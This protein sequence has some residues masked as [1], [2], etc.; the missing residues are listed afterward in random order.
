[1][2]PGG[3]GSA[4]AAGSGAGEGGGGSRGGGKHAESEG[5]DVWTDCKMLASHEQ[6][7]LLQAYIWMHMLY[8]TGIYLDVATC[9]TLISRT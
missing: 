9:S 4:A 3:A 2:L 8:I 6:A 1:M 5:K 7:H